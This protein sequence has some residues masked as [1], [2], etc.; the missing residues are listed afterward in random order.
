M[1]QTEPE[2]EPLDEFNDLATKIVEK[3][4]EKF[5]GIDLN[6]IAARQIT[7]KDRGEK[8]NKLY[9]VLA[10]KPPIRPDDCKYAFYIIIHKSDWD[11]L[12][13]KHRLLLI[14]QALHTIILDENGEMTEGK[15]A[16]PDMKDFASM[17]RTFG[18]DYLVKDNVPDLLEDEI[19]WVD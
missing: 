14:A 12:E 15:V 17:L 6:I 16:S 5:S 2:Y 19:K 4:S 7:N 18:P 8:N 10:V 13:Q 3:H 9:E 11:V 1:A